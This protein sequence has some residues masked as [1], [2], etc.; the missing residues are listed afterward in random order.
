MSWCG[1]LQGVEIQKPA[2]ICKKKDSKKRVRRIATEIERKY[3]CDI[4]GC[5]KAYG[6]EG[7]LRNHVKLKHTTRKPQEQSVGIPVHPIQTKHRN[8]IPAPVPSV[9]ESSQLY[10]PQIC[11][12]MPNFGEQVQF[13]VVPF[14]TS[15]CVG[16]VYAAVV[17]NGDQNIYSVEKV[18]I[19]EQWELSKGSMDISLH[20]QPHNSI[21]YYFEDFCA[22]TDGS[23]VAL[24]LE[25]L[26]HS[27]HD[28]YLSI[29]DS[30]DCE[31]F[32]RLTQKPKFYSCQVPVISFYETL[33]WVEIDDF[34]I[35]ASLY[36]CHVIKLRKLSTSA[37]T[38]LLESIKKS[39]IPVN[40]YIVEQTRLQWLQKK[41][42]PLVELENFTMPTETLLGDHSSLLQDTSVDCVVD[43][44]FGELDCY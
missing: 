3:V 9:Y 18:S 38:A 15:F 24:K 5:R 22:D 44:M 29:S 32:L 27:I 41:F 34:T 20:V 37:Q 30:G 16:R 2:R 43:T 40:N 42:S 35:G 14:D 19:G 1:K 28:F 10:T 25:I 8:I 26:M 21:S 6:S 7:A 33:V 4:D 23:A 36:C 39:G 13:P 12:P 17:S 31:L 11:F